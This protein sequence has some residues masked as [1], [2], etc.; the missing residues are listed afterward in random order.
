MRWPQS[1]CFECNDCR[2]VWL[3]LFIVPN[4]MPSNQ[5]QMKPVMMIIIIKV[6]FIWQIIPYGRIIMASKY[7]KINQLIIRHHFFWFYLIIP[8]LIVILCFNQI[9]NNLKIKKWHRVDI[10]IVKL[11]RTMMNEKE[12]YVY[13][14]LRKEP[15]LYIA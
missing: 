12:K 10:M 13:A 2:V 7:Q 8:A 4:V 9:E 1:L 14:L 6:I 3:K 5:N 11:M 15:L